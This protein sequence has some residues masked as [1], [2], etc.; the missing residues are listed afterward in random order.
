VFTPRHPK[1]SPKVSDFAEIETKYDFE[2]LCQE[3]VA[4]IERVQIRAKG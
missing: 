3:A 1:T 2:G 4:N